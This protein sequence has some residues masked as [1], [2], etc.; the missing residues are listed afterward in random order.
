MAALLGISDGD[1]LKC[2]CD[3]EE[4]LHNDVHDTTIRA[5]ARK[6]LRQ[7]LGGRGSEAAEDEEEAKAK[8]QSR[9]DPELKI[10]QLLPDGASLALPCLAL[11]CAVCLYP[12]ACARAVPS[13]QSPT[14]QP[15]LSLS[16]THCE[17][18]CLTACACLHA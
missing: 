15:P 7:V 9:L 1:N 5:R 17:F 13:A 18:G 14:P 3:R 8:R 11:P 6:L 12:L 4:E 2:K 10:H 16:L